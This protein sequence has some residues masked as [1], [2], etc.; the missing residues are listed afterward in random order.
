MAKEL[1]FVASEDDM[2]TA[3]ERQLDFEIKKV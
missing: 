3:I 1:P 2:V